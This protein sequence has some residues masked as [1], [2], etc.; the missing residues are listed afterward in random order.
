MSNFIKLPNGEIVRR[1][2]IIAV[3][4]GNGINGQTPSVVID[5][6][7]LGRMSTLMCPC[8]GVQARDDLVAE[9]MR[10]IDGGDEE[11]EPDT[12]ESRV[13]VDVAELAVRALKAGL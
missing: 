7:V 5:Y 8:E 10:R 9:I 1:D 3:R 12:P 2:A 4:I 6:G 11:A 13:D